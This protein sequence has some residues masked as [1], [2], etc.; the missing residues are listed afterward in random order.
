M[1]EERKAEKNSHRKKLVQNQFFKCFYSRNP[2][3][4]G[5]LWLR[6]GKKFEKKATGRNKFKRWM[7][8]IFRKMNFKGKFDVYVCFRKCPPANFL[9]FQKPLRSLFSKIK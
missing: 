2:E 6:V 4:K 1:Q 3:R 5:K 9:F 7:R 8:E